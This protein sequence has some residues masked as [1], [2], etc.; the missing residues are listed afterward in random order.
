MVS[1]KVQRLVIVLTLFIST[2]FL[3]GCNGGTSSSSLSEAAINIEVRDI[4]TKAALDNVQV[5]VSGPD[6]TNAQGAVSILRQVA[7]DSRGKA[8]IGSLSPDRT[9]TI[10]IFKEGYANPPQVA[11]A[12]PQYIPQNVFLVEQGKTYEVI[13]YL[14]R[15]DSPTTGTVKGYV[16]NRVTGEAI[17]NASVYNSPVGNVASVIDTTNKS[18]KPG[19]YEL[20]NLPSGNVTINVAIPGVATNVTAQVTIPSNGSI[21]YDIMV[22]PGSG[23]LHGNVVAAAN[24]TLAPGTYIVQALRNGTDIIATLSFTVTPAGGTGGANAGEKSHEYTIAGVPVI[25]PGS[26]ATYTVKV[27][28]DVAHMISP[29][30]G[31]SGIVLR[32]AGGATGTNQIEVTPI[33]VQSE[34]GTVLVT[35][36]HPAITNPLSES[37]PTLTTNA[38]QA[39]ISIDGALVETIF[40]NEGPTRFYRYRINNVPVGSR[41]LRIN[42]PGHSVSG[43]PSVT[44]VKD[45]EVQVLYTLAE[46]SASSAAKFK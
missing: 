25:L 32:P 43:T 44:A 5:M 37:E 11:N 2:V 9:Y 1:N 3:Y 24:E 26:T 41:N 17:S 31:V 14:I 10:T 22:D 27:I 40:V 35:L 39:S 4:T 45:T 6:P 29:A 30:G 34:K 36:F 21:D 15:S 38:P 20:S 33:T 23:S 18:S 42:F 16:K 8:Q 46:G 7:T 19:Y 13:G 12:Q 28:A